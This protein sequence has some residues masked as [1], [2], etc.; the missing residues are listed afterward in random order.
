M[1]SGEES[2]EDLVARRRGRYL[3]AIKAGPATVQIHNEP[4]SRQTIIEVYTSDR[5]GLLF[6]ITSTLTRLGLQIHVAKI[7]TLVDQVLDVFYVT[8]QDGRKVDGAEKQ[9]EI[10]A[11]IVAALATPAA[12]ASPQAAV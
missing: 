9:A 7:T 10:Q 1:L 5:V 3:R 6:M 12:T 8:D 2:V 4:S 11:A